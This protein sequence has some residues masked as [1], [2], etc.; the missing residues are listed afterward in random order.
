M[1][2]MDRC[3]IVE[4]SKSPIAEGFVSSFEQGEMDFVSNRNISH[5]MHTG[6]RVK[7]YVYNASMGECI[8]D[9]IVKTAILHHV[10]LAGLKM[11]TNLQK[12]NNTR[13]ATELA[14]AVRY[15]CDAVT[16]DNVR[17][18]EKPV[19]ITILN[20]SAE[21]F[22]ISC[23]ERFDIGFTFIFTFHVASREIPVH[24]Q[25]VRREQGHFGFHYGCH[26]TDVPLNDQNEIHRWVF[27]QQ[28]ALRR[29]NKI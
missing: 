3:V 22:L 1:Y 4:Q 21:G 5:W 17:E 19:P 20:V 23:K 12:R 11:V 28:I 16:P 18:F 26:L 24:A 7:I 14:Y 29:E 25:I 27:S 8:Y 13:V 2:E 6:Q 9:G 10:Q 15:Y